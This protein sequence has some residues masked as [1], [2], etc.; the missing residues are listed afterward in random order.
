VNDDDR[1]AKVVVDRSLCP[2][3]RRWVL[4]GRWATADVLVTGPVTTLHKLLVFE[5]TIYFGVR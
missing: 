4:V 5:F 3:C 1:R 2:W